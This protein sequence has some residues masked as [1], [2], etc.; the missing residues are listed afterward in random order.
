M[1]LD[2]KAIA[3]QA[4]VSVATVSRA[5]SR[6]E[7]V[8]PATREKILAL[9]ED[10]GYKPNPLARGLV[11]GRTGQIA[12]VVPTLN[13]PFFAQLVEGC[14]KFLIPRGYNLI[15]F[16]SQEYR[17]K[18]LAILRNLDQRRLDG[19][20]LSGSGFFPDDYHPIL[21]QIRMPAVLIEHL[22]DVNQLSSVYIDDYAGTIMA[23]Q[24]LVNNGHRQLG[25]IAG[26]PHMLTTSRRLKAVKNVLREADLP[27]AGRQIV[28]GDY[29][30]LES[31]SDGLQALLK[32]P[33]PPTAV[34]AFNDIL[35]IGAL[36]AARELGLK[37]PGD[38]AVIGFDDIPMAAY[39]N[40]PL[41]TIRSPS[42]ELGQQAA[43]LL[44]EQL[45]REKAPV[46]KVLLPV[47]LVL[48]GSC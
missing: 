39:C 31:G 7:M 43:R 20:I 32:S 29:S 33:H 30:S 38:L 36:K 23:V 45:S 42:L 41:S 15:I 8:R 13:N 11:T 34:F 27:F 6:P 35:A 18:E 26:S 3:E 46:K 22:A 48:R 1:A 40:P 14:Q 9:V 5:L 25:V 12:L 44:L 24:H 28:Y 21:A 47:E 37:I 4:G 19:L 10:L 2:M 16:S 17:E